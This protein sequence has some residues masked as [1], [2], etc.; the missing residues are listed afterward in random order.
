M[1][2][3][4]D[5]YK[6]YKIERMT[7][8]LDWGPHG[9]GLELVNFT[10]DKSALRRCLCLRSLGC[11]YEF[12]H[13]HGTHGSV[14]SQARQAYQEAVSLDATQHGCLA[15][16]AQLEASTVRAFVNLLCNLVVDRAM[17]WLCAHDIYIYV[18]CVCMV[19]RDTQKHDVS[20]DSYFYMRLWDIT[21]RP[22]L[23]NAE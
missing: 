9:H 20:L 22:W 3:S 5:D 23:P 2:V 16:L 13:V 10:S 21:R 11:N 12:I 15:N 8:S 6:S 1:S 4:L 19:Y 7:C 14:V 17:N 18:T